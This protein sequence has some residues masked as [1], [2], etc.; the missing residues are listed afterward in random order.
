MIGEGDPTQFFDQLS[1]YDMDAEADL[2]QVQSNLTML[3][4]T[5]GFI[6]QDQVESLSELSAHPEP[7]NESRLMLS[8][9]KSEAEQ[10][11]SLR[12]DR[13]IESKVDGGQAQRPALTVANYENGFAHLG[14]AV[15]GWEEF[16]QQHWGFQRGEALSRGTEAAPSAR[17]ELRELEDLSQIVEDQTRTLR[18]LREKT[19]EKCREAAG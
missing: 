10:L 1:L 18:E 15:R 11:S 7:G 9:P 14:Q 19:P 2:D 13:M 17:P 8:E 12:Y 5:P 6:V 4:V 16:S 3:G